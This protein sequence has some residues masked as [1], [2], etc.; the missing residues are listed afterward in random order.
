MKNTPNTPN[1]FFIASIVIL[2]CLTILFYSI[3][4]RKSL[5]AQDKNDLPAQNGDYKNGDYKIGAED[6][7]AISVWRNDQ[8]NREVVV[9][10][11]GKISFPLLD[12]LKVTG[13][14]P[15]EVKKIITKKLA[16]YIGDPE[17]TVILKGMNN[18]R[19][20]IAG[21]AAGLPGVFNLKRKVTLF[22]L[23]D[24]ADKK[25]LTEN[26]DLRRAYLL[27]GQERLPV[28]FEKLME[29]DLTQDVELLPE[30]I[31]YLP[32]NF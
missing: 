15:L 17:V 11:D 24:M 28:D 20:Y 31:I 29:G 25:A 18:N 22:Q 7:L 5:Y 32:D 12:D 30:D 4:D 26:V 3:I 27:R 6:V 1:T 14:T 10:P 23:L 8:L 9:R 13:L 21:G 16:L 19:V 2:F